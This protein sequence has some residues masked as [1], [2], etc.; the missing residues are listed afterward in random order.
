LPRI[1]SSASIDTRLRKSIAVG[2]RFDSPSDITGNST[3]KPPAPA[4]RGARGQQGAECAL[5]G[6]S[7]DHVLQMP[8]TAARRIRRPACPGFHPAAMHD[9]VSA[10]AA[11]PPLRPKLSAVAAHALRLFFVDPHFCIKR[12]HASC[13]ALSIRSSIARCARSD[14]GADRIRTSCGGPT[15]AGAFGSVERQPE[16]ERERC[17]DQI[18]NAFTIRFSTERTMV[19]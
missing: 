5:Q 13:C 19:L 6:V 11:K 10:G 1:D 7:S 14:R 17:V 12:L 3:G 15:K 2:R 9:G 8:M 16:T 4:R 18:A